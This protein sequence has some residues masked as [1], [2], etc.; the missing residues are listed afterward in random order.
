MSKSK[1]GLPAYKGR[2]LPV[3]AANR[4]MQILLIVLA[5]GFI[6]VGLREGWFEPIIDFIMY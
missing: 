4:F 5:A 3:K 2:P 6:K 1:W